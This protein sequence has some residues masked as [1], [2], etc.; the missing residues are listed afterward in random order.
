MAT[1]E[2]LNLAQQ[3]FSTLTSL[4]HSLWIQTIYY[5]SAI[6]KSPDQANVTLM[7]ISAMMA[8][9]SA[10]TSLDK[11]TAVINDATALTALTN[12]L[13][14]M[15]CTIGSANMLYLA[16][17]ASLAA[18]ITALAGSSSAADLS[19]ACAAFQAAVPQGVYL[20]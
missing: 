8:A 10:Q 12:G 14:G 11:V 3:C 13:T 2:E 1:I 15:G 20:S 18:W 17:K 5:Q 7:I 9:H 4:R 19:T 6:A 16:V